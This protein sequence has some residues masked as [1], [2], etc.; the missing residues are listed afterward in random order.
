MI[1]YPDPKDSCEQ[2][3]PS[4]SG[5]YS[6]EEIKETLFSLMIPHLR[7]VTQEGIPKKHIQDCEWVLE[8]GGGNTTQQKEGKHHKQV[9]EVPYMHFYQKTFLKYVAAASSSDCPPPFTTPLSHR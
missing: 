7:E 9:K 3:L 5:Y 8:G 6:Y 1:H 4:D 2:N